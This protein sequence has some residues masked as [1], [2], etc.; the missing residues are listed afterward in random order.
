MVAGEGVI[1]K[2]RRHVLEL[3][4]VFIFT[5][6]VFAVVVTLALMFMVLGII[7]GV[8]A[9]RFKRVN[10]FPFAL[11]GIPA[12]LFG[13]RCLLMALAGLV[14]L[15]LYVLVLGRYC[16]SSVGCFI[17]TPM[18]SLIHY[19]P[20][21][22]WNCGIL[23]L[24]I[25]WAWQRWKVAALAR[26]APYSLVFVR[27][28]VNGQLSLARMRRMSRLEVERIMGLVEERA[29]S[30][31]ISDAS[32]LMVEDKYDYQKI[33][34]LANTLLREWQFRNEDERERERL[35][36]QAVLEAS[37]YAREPH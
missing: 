17:G 33:E 2:P 37:E 18:A 19:W 35:A 24:F 32:Q 30:L 14:L 11:R 8:D 16:G 15:A 12:Q 3:F 22:L 9:L 31:G 13:V 34:S 5:P 7:G 25:D 10:Y 1:R 27:H 6:N 36:L 4:G 20:L 26:A 23:Y 28:Y 21:I 29:S